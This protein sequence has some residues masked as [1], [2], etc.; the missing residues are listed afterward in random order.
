MC[1]T[2]RALRPD[3][4]VSWPELHD[5]LD[6]AWPQEQ[7]EEVDGEL[8]HVLAFDNDNDGSSY[9]GVVLHNMWKLLKKRTKYERYQVTKMK[10]IIIIS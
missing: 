8:W 9:T 6:T 2:V 5:D 4:G 7:G 1:V 10:L 3:Q